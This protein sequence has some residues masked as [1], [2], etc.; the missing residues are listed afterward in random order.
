MDLIFCSFCNQSFS[1]TDHHPCVSKIYNLLNNF[2]QKKRNDSFLFKDINNLV[3]QGGGMKGICYLGVLQQLIKENPNIFKD[4][5]RVAGTS[6]GALVALYLALGLD[7]NTEIEELLSRD[8]G[9]VLDD[10]LALKVR[11]Q[12]K[13]LLFS[14]TEYRNFLVKD[15][16]LAARNLLDRL[17]EDFK[18]VIKSKQAKN[19]LHDLVKGILKYC[20]YKFG[21]AA[22]IFMKIAGNLITNQIVKWIFAILKSQSSL[23][24]PVVSLATTISPL[25]SRSPLQKGMLAFAYNQGSKTSLDDLIRKEFSTMIIHS[26]FGEV[27]EN[28]CNVCLNEIIEEVEEKDENEIKGKDLEIS[29]P[30]QGISLNYE[31]K[32]AEASAAPQEEKENDIKKAQELS[33]AFQRKAMNHEGK[34]A[35]TSAVP[36]EILDDNVEFYKSQKPSGLALEISKEELK[37]DLLYCALGELVWFILISQAD[38]NGLKQ[39]IGLFSGEKVKEE[40]IENVIKSKVGDYKGDIT[41]KVLSELKDPNGN[42]FK[43]FYITAFDSSTLKTDVFSYEHTPNVLV[44]DAVRASISFPVFF[45][46]TKIRENGVPRRIYFNEGLDSEE[47]RYMDGGVLDNYPIW[48]FD[49]MK[50]HFEEEEWKSKQKIPFSNSKTLGFMILDKSRIDIYNQ[51]YFD[52]EL[53][54][55]KRVNKQQYQS[56]IGYI[57]GSLFNTYLSESEPNIFRRNGDGFRSV[58]VDNLGMSVLAFNLTEIDKKRIIESGQKAVQFYKDR[59]PKEEFVN[60]SNLENGTLG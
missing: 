6:A 49:E 60:G 44:A 56:S 53:T 34:K 42:K 32:K 21:T 39:E 58:F 51:P 52:P 9:D 26:T 24:S 16:F 12:V 30:F 33:R 31:G 14:R 5:K 22:K 43:P 25:E 15:I 13:V 35:E 57:M 41:F 54:K 27:L 50:Y 19:E 17:E 28:A 55:M 36:Q 23:E 8:F 38:A 29:L 47:I 4:M 18:N 3:F 10:G 11:V 2:H 59:F 1:P 37:G 7:P 45:T 40:L 48:M 20:A 46:P